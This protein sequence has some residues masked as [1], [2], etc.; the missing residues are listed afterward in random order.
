RPLVDEQRQHDSDEP[1][2]AERVVEAAVGGARDGACHA[3]AGTA[4]AKDGAN[5]AERAA[6]L[7]PGGGHDEDDKG[8]QEVRSYPREC[9][10]CSRL[11]Y[12][13]TSR[14]PFE[15]VKLPVMI[16]MRST[17]AQMPQP[18]SVNVC[19]TPVPIFPT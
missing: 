18:P 5:K 19:A 15:S 4:Y 1:V 12:R 9:L 14:W 17:S 3:A 2:V 16:V 13:F 11:H 6:S 7:D 8:K 10:R